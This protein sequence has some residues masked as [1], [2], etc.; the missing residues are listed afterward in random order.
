[1]LNDQVLMQSQ[2]L[3]GLKE[4]G[5]SHIQIEFPNQP[6]DDAQS[7]SMSKHGDPGKS[8]KFE[9]ENT[10]AGSNLRNNGNKDQKFN[11][12]FIS[13]DSESEASDND[14]DQ[15]QK[16]IDFYPNKNENEQQAKQELNSDEE[17]EIQMAKSKAQNQPARVN[18]FA[19]RIGNQG[20]Q[21]S[22]LS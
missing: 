19:A 11:F 9:T 15:H 16:L 2:K 20:I 18:P 17:F 21:A 10:I 5:L 22:Q 7:K 13:G 1:M 14:E 12:G 8:S 3:P 6:S 4:V